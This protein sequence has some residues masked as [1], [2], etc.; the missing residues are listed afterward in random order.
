[1]SELQKLKATIDGLANGA[2]QTGGSL[3]QFRSKFT[4]QMSQVRAAIGGSAQRKDQEV[5]N[6]LEAANKQVA[7]AIAA[8]ENAAK[9]ASNYGK[10]L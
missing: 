9:V 2:K 5:I 8:L 7:T 3:G 1:M 6:A 10:S 4:S